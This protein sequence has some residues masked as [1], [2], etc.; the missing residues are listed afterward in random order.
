MDQNSTLPLPTRPA[1]AAQAQAVTAGVSPEQ[2]ADGK[3]IIILATLGFAVV[4]LIQAAFELGIIS[5][6]FENWRPI[7]YAYLLWGIALGFGL[8]RMRGAAGHRSLFVLP[9]V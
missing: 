8:V 3:R 1:V 2:A 7:A 6:G 9:A 5:W 4:V